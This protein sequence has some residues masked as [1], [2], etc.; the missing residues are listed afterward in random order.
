MPTNDDAATADALVAEARRA[1]HESLIFLA[2]PEA[3][4]VR[5]LIA[6]LETAVEVRTAIRMSAPVPSPP[7]D[8][9]ALRKAVADAIRNATCTGNCGKPEEECA[10]ERIQPFAWH[11]GTLAVVE[12]SPEQFADAVL[13]VLPPPADRAADL[14]AW[15]ALYEPGNV[16]TYL[17]GYAND[18]DAA[19]G[20]AEAWMR[21]QAEVTGRL[22]WV[23]DEQM[24]TG[25]YDR[26]FELIE[27]HGDGV[28]T[29]TSIVVRRRVADET[30]TT[31]AQARRGDQFEAWL[32]AQRDDHRDDDRG[33]WSAYDDLLDRY[34]LHADT[35]TPL[36][37]HLC[38]GQAVG[39]CECLEQPAAGARQDGAQR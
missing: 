2:A 30:A 17:I 19:T 15:E 4:R 33:R 37:E 21:S 11:H 7:A 24:A 9:A 5:S 18:Q 38:E 39:D 25:R 13:P 26:W 14:P 16:S 28:D 35:G 20:M 22:E 27:C 23:D 1:I 3:D 31:E 36:G 29:G 32:K 10:R 6:D 34:R 12:G 8:P